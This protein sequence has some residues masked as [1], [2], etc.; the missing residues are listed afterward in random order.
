MPSDA[1]S[2]A[3]LL[4][5]VRPLLARARESA[6]NPRYVLVAPSIFDVIAGYRR[7]DREMGMPATILGLEI[8]RA[9]DPN[10][11]PRVF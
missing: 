1:P 10:A 6:D 7:R 5:E 11:A 4:D 9:D 2:L 8:V 3:A